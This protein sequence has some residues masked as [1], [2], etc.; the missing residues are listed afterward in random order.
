MLRWQARLDARWADRVVPWATAAVLFAV[1]TALAV[2]RVERLEAGSALARHVQA[3]WLLASGEQPETTIA[4]VGNLFA[5]RFPVLLVPLAALTRV[6]PLTATL[7]AVQS[8]SLALGAVPLWHLA[9]RVA[10]L[11]VGASAT[12]VFAY[13]LHPA[14]ADLDLADFNPATMA[15]TP[16]LA[17]A[18]FAE[19]RQWRRFALA[20]VVVVLWSSEFALVIAGMGALLL[21]EG[22]RRAGLRT[23]IA[24][25]AWAGVALF[26]VQVPLGSTGIVAP[27]AFD[28]YGS[29]G[30]DVL[31]EMVRN[32]FRP[33]G[34][35]LAE[36]N[37]RLIVWV[38]G[39]LLFVPLLAIRKLAPVAALQVLYLVADVSLTGPTGGGRMVPVVAF[40]FV[41]AAFALR[42]LGRA[43]LDRVLVDRR[44]LSLMIAAALAAASLTSLLSPYERP[45]RSESP[46][47]PDLRVA[48]AR[49][50]PIVPVR[51]PAA[52]APRVAERS[53][54]YVLEDEFVPTADGAPP[55]ASPSA[56]VRGVRGLVVDLALFGLDE[57]GAARLRRDLRREGF[58]QVRRSGNL[59]IYLP[60]EETPPPVDE[61]PTAPVPIP[62][63]IPG[64]VPEVPPTTTSPDAVPV[65]VPPP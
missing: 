56:L 39:P 17:A 29:N 25:A 35:V 53:S 19:Q 8:A 64:P 5:D 52:L 16:L 54:V 41:A 2:S 24:G 21:F 46:L 32:P 47:E 61:A 7:L 6:L 26:V 48:L 13:A 23:L 55:F 42:R 58:L 22:E 33:L 65:P 63:P 57:E 50:P 37:V 60:F 1:W 28:A 9:R 14:L 34:D 18:Y 62:V 12:L 45:W 51:V 40:S 11:G 4:P 3:V 15:L 59:V 20:S 10:N 49:V 43:R 27:G 31:I 38:L 36:A 30:L 44:L